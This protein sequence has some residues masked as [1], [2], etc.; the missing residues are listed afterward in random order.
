MIHRIYFEWYGVN[1]YNPESFGQ[2]TF[3]DDDG[4]KIGVVNLDFKY[5]DL[6]L[7]IFEMFEKHGDNNIEMIYDVVIK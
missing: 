5:Q 4:N 7:L 2:I 1:K 6:F 3:T